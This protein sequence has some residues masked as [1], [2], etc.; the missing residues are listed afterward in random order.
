MNARDYINKKKPNLVDNWSCPSDLLSYG[1]VAEL[2][3]AY[4]LHRL[5]EITEEGKEFL[6]RIEEELINDQRM[7]PEMNP[8]SRSWGYEEGVLISQNE[9]KWLLQRLKLLHQ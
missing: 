1:Q 3:E 5:E 9:A 6:N 8:D 7:F 4:H 2:M